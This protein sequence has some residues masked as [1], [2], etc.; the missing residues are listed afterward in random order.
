[1]VIEADADDELPPILSIFLKA[2]SMFPK[3][4]FGM[5]NFDR[6]LFRASWLGFNNC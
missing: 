5:L 2:S 4:L 6:T 1:M 3:G